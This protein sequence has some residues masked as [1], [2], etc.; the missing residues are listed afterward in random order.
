VGNTPRGNT[1]PHYLSVHPHTRGEYSLKPRLMLDQRGSPPHAWGIHAGATLAALRLRFTPTRVGN[2]HQ[3]IFSRLRITVHPHTRGEYSR[4]RDIPTRS[5]G[6]PP[7]AW[8]IRRRLDDETMRLRFTPTRVGN[9][10]SSMRNVGALSVH[11]HTRGEYYRELRDGAR[12]DGSP[13]HAWGIRWENRRARELNRFT[14][15]RVG[16]T[17]TRVTLFATKTVHPH[18]RGEYVAVCQRCL[19]DIGSPPHAWGIR[20][21]CKHAETH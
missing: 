14:P 19:D 2:T 21:Y 16:N 4:R 8:G 10:V 17:I 20:T 15:T 1:A 3:I 12:V 6:S 9:T 7:H 11:P 5:R 18:T 13:P